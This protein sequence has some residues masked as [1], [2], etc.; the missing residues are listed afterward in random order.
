LAINLQTVKKVKL[1]L[2]FRFEGK[3]CQLEA[4]K[5]FKK[6]SCPCFWYFV[7][8]HKN[9]IDLGGYEGQPNYPNSYILVKP[10][11]RN[12]KAQMRFLFSF[13]LAESMKS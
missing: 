10:I 9:M 11:R 4:L 12:P 6:I 5:N 1:S 8:H 2:S 13:W 3:I 7:K